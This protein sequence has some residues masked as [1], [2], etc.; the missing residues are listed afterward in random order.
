MVTVTQIAPIDKKRSRIFFGQGEPIA[1]YNGEIRRFGIEQGKELPDEVILQIQEEILKK[2]IKERALYLLKSMDRTEE[3]IR[4]KLKKGYYNEELIDYAVDFLKEYGYINDRRYAENYI[5]TYTGRK[6][7]KN[8]QQALY[9][10]GISR[11]ITEEVFEIFQKET[12]DAGEKDMI[13][14]LL[15]KRRYRFEGADIKEK[16]REMG[17]LLRKGFEM[18]E[19]LFCLKNRPEEGQDSL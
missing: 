16:N 15:K 2:R 3:E 1:L 18:E 17:F 8:I 12:K 5:R 19:V 4:A 6:S 7:Q 9:L 11:E 13:Y 14:A 10:K